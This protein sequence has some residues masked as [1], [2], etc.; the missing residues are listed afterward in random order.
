M[1]SLKKENSK[2]QALCEKGTLHSHPETVHDERF[3]ENDFFDA[4]DLRQRR[5]LFRNSA[6]YAV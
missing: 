5:G 2:T 4:R 1:S 3:Q 6:G